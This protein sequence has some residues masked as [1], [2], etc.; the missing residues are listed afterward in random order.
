MSRQRW[1][2]FSRT[3]IL[4]ALISRPALAQL[5]YPGSVDILGPEE[6]VFDWTT[7]KCEQIDIPDT[8]ARFF[9]D[10]DGNI[11]VIASHYTNYRFIG[12]DF[13]SLSRD[14]A[15]AAIM[16]S[17]ED[18]DPSHFN[19]HEWLIS[20]YTLD[21]KT[22][23][24]IIH[25]E[26]H[27][28]EHT[29]QVSCPSG[30][31]LKCWYNALTFATST[32]SG[33]SYSHAAAPGH[34]LAAPPYQYVPD[35]GPYGVFGGSN[36]VY[37]PN[38]GY[39]YCM[40]QV[41]AYGLQQSGAGIMRT[42][43]L[44]DPTSWRAWD[45][46]GWNTRF[47]NPYT[48]TGFDPADHLV[49]P[50]GDGNIEKM[51]SSLT[52]NTYFNMWLLV[53]A[54]QKGGVWGFYYS[55]S[56]DL[57]HWTVRRRI[58]T[59][60]L[61]IDPKHKTNEDVLAYPVVVDH[62]DTTRN[63]EVTGREVYLYFT[64][65]HPGSTYDRD[66]VRVPIRF[67]KLQVSG[68][69]VNGKGDYQD[70][71]PGDGICLTGAGK[72]SFR[73]ALEESNARPPWYADSVMSISFNL[74]GTGPF[75]IT[76]KAALQDVWYP[77]N[78][79]GYTQPG[80]TPNSN[81]FADGINARPLIEINGN[82]Q[83]GLQLSGG[84]ST[85]RGLILNRQLGAA[86]TMTGDNYV[87]QGNFLNVD[88]SGSVNLTPANDG[89]HMYTS[90]YNLIGDTTAAGRNLIIG[91]VR[92]QGPD[93]RYNKVWGNYIGTDKTGTIKLDQW[94][95][96]VS[97]QG[98]AQFNTI[99]GMDVRM[100][101]LISGN[102]SHGV[103]IGG[104]GTSD[105][106]VLNNYI[107]VNAAATAPLGNG[108]MGVSINSGAEGNYIG[109]PGAGN[110][111]ADNREGGIAVD[112]AA[113]NF[114]QGNFIGTDISGTKD[115][116]NRAPG[117]TFFSTQEFYIG[118]AGAG[119][120]NVIAFNDD[121]GINILGNS[122]PGIRIW[123]NAIYRN[124]NRSGI[125]LGW[126]GHT[127]NDDG[128]A[129]TGPNNWQNHPVLIS[130]LSGEV[131]ING[132]LNS[133]PNTTYRI[134][135][136]ASDTC[137]P[138]GYGEGQVYLDA[139]AVT[140]DASG[141]ATINTTLTKVVAP[142]KYITATATAPDG[143]T[144]EFSN[145]V[146]AQT[147]AA[148]LMVSPDNIAH[149][150]GLG[151]STV[152]TLIIR[153]TG[154]LSAA[155]TLTWQAA[156]LDASSISGNIESGATQRIGITLDAANLTQGQYVD[157]LTVTSSDTSQAPI[158]I[159]VAL[160]V[161]A[162]PDIAV[163]PDSLNMSTT[164]GGNVTQSVMLKNT[165]SG[166]LNWEA[167]VDVQSAWL[168]A[169]SSAGTLQPGDS[170]EVSFTADASSLTPGAYNGTAFFNSNDPDED[171]FLIPVTLQVTGIGPT[172]SVSP[173]Q[174]AATVTQGDSSA[175]IVVIQNLG[176]ATLDWSVSKNGNWLAL[177][178]SSGALAPAGADSISL[179]MR[180]QGLA[181][182]THADTLRIQSNDAQ[183]PEVRVPISLQ[184]TNDRPKISVTQSS[185][186]STLDPGQSAEHH[187]SVGNIGLAEMQWSIQW[188]AAWATVSPG[189]SSTPP[190][191]WV[192]VTVGFSTDGLPAGDHIDTLWVHSTDPDKP[193][194]PVALFLTVT[195]KAP[196]IFV[197]QD[198]LGSRLAAGDSTRHP[199]VIENRGTA[200]LR[201][202]LAATAPWIKIEPDSGTLDSGAS[203]NAG[204][205]FF[206]R[207]LAAGTYRDTIV[208]TSNDADTPVYRIPAELIVEG[209]A[210]KPQIAVAPDTFRVR[211]QQGQA[212]VSN[213]E[214]R[215]TGAASLNYIVN[216]SAASK[217]INVQ[218]NSGVLAPWGR[219]T[220]AV[221]FSARD[222]AAGNYEGALMVNSNDPGR[223]QI[224]VPAY[225][226]V[227]AARPRLAV[228]P[229]SVKRV[230][231]AGDTAHVALWVCNRGS[232]ALTWE[233]KLP[234]GAR[235]LDAEPGSGSTA[236]GDSS[237]LLLKLNAFGMEADTYSDTLAVRGNDPETPEVRIPVSLTVEATVGVV[238]AGAVPH[239][240]W[241][242]QNHPNPFN[243]ETSIRFALPAPSEVQLIIMDIRGNRIR[244]LLD[245]P[246]ARGL[247][248]ARWDGRT[249]AGIPAGSGVYFC[250]LRVGTIGRT[251]A[252]LKRKMI[253]MR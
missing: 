218:N 228:N 143:S 220:L 123:G 189:S 226:T 118:G 35:A 17:H 188:Q 173:N 111:I 77:V 54:A 6:I 82:G 160:Q 208:V 76:L 9:R 15:N 89:V 224:L 177:S 234:V 141:N 67:N 210:E 32:D 87:I 74:S 24:A 134:E 43:T 91:G 122:G 11:Q 109:R 162:V 126:D 66:L 140:T 172:I 237:R 58:M 105:N 168:H 108:L 185:L 163:V 33:R 145:C 200:E 250:I 241:L 236:A 61:L 192:D 44:S 239:G 29:D 227:F 103:S 63:F 42:Q 184:V 243:P 178:R 235:W 148:F 19:D 215:N 51:H 251:P 49:A 132:T 78:I 222:S 219:R 211:V 81:A 70:K 59:A 23:Y 198:Q 196:D 40:V 104:S 181:L 36:I 86:I 142:G 52:W 1:V 64:R 106:E 152:D 68:F 125:D 238:G 170:V 175:Q 191:K 37:N 209:T 147:A 129:D 138:S 137:D 14:C 231:A 62:N 232:A 179:T 221:S 12:P 135:F 4:I 18:G 107:G 204:V 79:D 92:I 56:K 112:N 214:I 99:G 197:S 113:R 101:N 128:D 45:G 95:A 20:T 117:M 7:D 2:E 230:V 171:P 133:M 199:V 75:T 55:L 202:A 28:H 253:L 10:A 216:W 115:W 245:G 124:D 183:A 46:A 144:S 84:N 164:Q 60:N 131:Q 110:M 120:G 182:G 217:W 233:V 16:T 246:R 194:V 41:E 223:P 8:P 85:I 207:G 119:E 31:Y 88:T 100:R 165:G 5:E 151:E 72:C 203:V 225:M 167:R 244:Y 159:P 149:T 127:Y 186:V 166:A 139:M 252:I 136:F 176:N 65:W 57:I 205:W 153:N 249:D 187:F 157:T 97:L 156:W 27:G 154:A 34:L 212:F 213:L 3:T 193:K 83:A 22:I 73:A 169:G 71:N 150:V 114:V 48:E 39:Y 38:D 80:A 30:D 146:Q 248:E 229:E 247:H 96:G 155:W 180:T 69:V 201:W 116:G 90:S 13:N 93:S 195:N 240:F 102:N 25:N 130:A 53:G 190:G 121:G 206:T 98:D 158:S 242:A 50:I 47:V 26:F 21:G 161:T 94:A 174:I